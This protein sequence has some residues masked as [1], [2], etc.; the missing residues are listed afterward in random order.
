MFLDIFFGSGVTYQS[1][2]NGSVFHSGVPNKKSL[3]YKFRRQQQNEKYRKIV[4]SIAIHKN[5]DIRDRQGGLGLQ[6]SKCKHGFVS[7]EDGRMCLECE[8]GVDP[9]IKMYLCFIKIM[10]LHF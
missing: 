7:S 4:E 6:C 3:T 5:H 10:H 2:A 8:N 1:L 9:G